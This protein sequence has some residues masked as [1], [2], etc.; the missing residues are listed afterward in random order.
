MLTIQQH[1]NEDGKHTNSKGAHLQA[2]IF[3]KVPKI[4]ELLFS[5]LSD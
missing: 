4:S 1:L 2:Y 3:A 5:Q